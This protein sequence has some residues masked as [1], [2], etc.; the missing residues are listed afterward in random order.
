M[1]V[2]QDH[3]PDS[4]LRAR[5]GGVPALP[6]EEE[7][8]ESRW[9]FGDPSP[10][11]RERVVQARLSILLAALGELPGSRADARPGEGL[12][13]LLDKLCS[14]AVVIHDKELPQGGVALEHVVVAPRGL[15]VVSPAWAPVPLRGPKPGRGDGRARAYPLPSAGEGRRRSRIVRET[16]RRGKALSAWL[17]QTAWAGTPVW[18]AV[19]S[20]PV[21]GLPVEPAV[22]LDG[23]WLGDIERLASWLASGLDLDGPRRSAL[24]RFLAAELPAG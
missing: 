4:T 18:A 1:R 8:W 7:A 20:A 11:G 13:R 6:G 23:L 12:A 16:L 22:M 9:R 21:L 14:C 10:T 15:V 24:G 19:C 5:R 17:D 3:R 2:P